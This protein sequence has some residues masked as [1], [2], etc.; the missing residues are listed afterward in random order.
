MGHLEAEFLADALHL[1]V[2]R[3]NVAEDPVDVLVAAHLEEAAE[4]FGAQAVPW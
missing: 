3:K 2:F 1:A 4:Q